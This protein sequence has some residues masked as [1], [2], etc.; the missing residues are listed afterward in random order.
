MIITNPQ[1]IIK[2]DIFKYA[3]NK[4][5]VIMIITNPQK[6]IKHDIFKYAINKKTCHHDYFYDIINQQK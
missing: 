1:K 5:Y 6:I 4:N 3:I 2:H